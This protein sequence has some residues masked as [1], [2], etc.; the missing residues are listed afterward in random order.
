[1]PED[2]YEEWVE[3]RQAELRMLYLDL[4]VELAG[5]YAER[6]EHERALKAMR[7]VLSAEPTREEAH[8]SLMRLYA[9]SGRRGE[10]IRQ[11][12]RLEGALRNELGAEPAA[13][14]QDLHGEILAG[15]FRRSR[16]VLPGSPGCRTAHLPKARTSFVGREREVLEVRQSLAMTGLLTLAGAGGVGKTRLALEIAEELSSTYPDGVWLVELAGLTDGALLPLVV[17]LSLRCASN[18]AG[19]SPTRSSTP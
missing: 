8:A 11:Y 10:A 9:L 19:R 7:C 16:T 1:L 4:L 18:L 15:I 14:S 2:R 12:E 13:E 17:A 3:G 5:L 6:G